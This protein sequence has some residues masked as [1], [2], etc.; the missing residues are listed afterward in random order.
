MLRNISSRLS[1]NSLL[2]KQVFSENPHALRFLHRTTPINKKSGEFSL[3]EEGGSLDEHIDTNKSKKSVKLYPGF[4][5]SHE[6]RISYE[7][8]NKSNKIEQ[9]KLS[10]KKAIEDFYGLNQF[11]YDDQ[12]QE[13]EQTGVDE[14]KDLDES[15]LTDSQFDID[16]VTRD[17]R[18]EN[19]RDICCVEIPEESNYADYMLIGTCLSERHMNSTFINL[20]KKFKK[21]SKRKKTNKAFLGLVVI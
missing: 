9:D 3:K 7:A 21:S 1:L 17:L 11:E 6:E 2:K 8:L 4:Q 18:M 12:Q 5:T 20:N 16:S 19:V 13:Q 14:T 10:A 15:V